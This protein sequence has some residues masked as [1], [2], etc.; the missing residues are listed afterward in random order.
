MGFLK[1]DRRELEFKGGV[2][3]EMRGVN[4]DGR[5]QQHD[6]GCGLGSQGCER[7]LVPLRP[8]YF[9]HKSINPEGACGGLGGV[10]LVC[11]RG[12]IPCE[13]DTLQAGLDLSQQLQPL[14]GQTCLVQEQSGHIAVRLGPTADQPAPDRIGFEVYG[15]DGRDRGC[16][17]RRPY[18][19]RSDHNQHISPEPYQLGHEAGQPRDIALRRAQED[20]LA[21]DV[22]ELAPRR[23][24]GGHR[25]GSR[26]EGRGVQVTDLP[27]G[28]RSLGSG[29]LRRGDRTSEATQK[30]T[31]SHS[32]T[33]LA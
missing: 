14:A 29:D 11:P 8:A 19:L 13:G 33:S 31:P 18:C 6:A 20:R 22:A 21:L 10:H 28:A 15:D 23:P 30:G 17:A 5:S 27:Q 7:R 4:E 9:K 32:S 2:G 24:K 12:W 1:R 26:I 25:Q 16:R 3:K